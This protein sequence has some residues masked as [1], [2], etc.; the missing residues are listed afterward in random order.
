MAPIALENEDHSRDAAFNKAMHGKS[1]DSRG[2]FRS[3]INKD[4]DAHKAATEEYFKHWDNK[5][6]G[7]ETAEIREV[8]AAFFGVHGPQLT[9][10]PGPESRVC[11]PYTTLL[12]S[13]NRSIRI[14]LGRMLSLLPLRIR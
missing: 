8:S 12:Q 11:D 7:T 3:M 5:S 4:H 1:A 14:W 2:G 6:A 10:L 13:R 9:R